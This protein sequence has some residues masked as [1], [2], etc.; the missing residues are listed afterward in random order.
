[1]QDSSL[2]LADSDDDSMYNT[3]QKP[4]DSQMSKNPP[5]TRGGLK[6]FCS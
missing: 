3:P 4:S 5:D 6:R 1:M 2:D